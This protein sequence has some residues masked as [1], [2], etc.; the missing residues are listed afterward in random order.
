MH[1]DRGEVVVISRGQVEEALVQALEIPGEKRKQDWVLL[2]KFFSS[3]F[4]G[5]LAL[6][7]YD[8]IA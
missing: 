3:F 8:S 4:L 7:T 1:Q 6:L 5:E 2:V